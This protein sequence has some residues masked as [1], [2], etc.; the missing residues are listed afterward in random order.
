MDAPHAAARDGA[1]SRTLPPADVAFQEFQAALERGVEPLPSAALAEP[2]EPG[3]RVGGAGGG[4]LQISGFTAHDSQ[5]RSRNWPGQSLADV[6]VHHHCTVRSHGHKRSC[7]S[8][9]HTL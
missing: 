4:G 5:I 8:R 6:A 3:G 2:E 9:G 7:A 1:P